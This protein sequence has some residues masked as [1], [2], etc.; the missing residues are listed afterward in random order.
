MPNTSSLSKFLKASHVRDGDILTFIDAGVI[1]QKE[2]KK[3]DGS[4]DISP[5]LEMTVEIN[6]DRKTYSP[7][8]QSR[9]FLEEVYGNQTENWVGK[10]AVVMIGLANNGNE[11]IISKP[12]R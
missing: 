9:K 1:V 5:M 4:V 6:G 8:G 3:K 10:Q 11:V 2:F 12:K 7:N